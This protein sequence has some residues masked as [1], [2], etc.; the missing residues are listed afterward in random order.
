MSLSEIMFSALPPDNGAPLHDECV[1]AICA[2][3]LHLEPYQRD[4]TNVKRSGEWLN[5]ESRNLVPGGLVKLTLG[6]LIPLCLQS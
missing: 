2:V 5:M 6:G 3:Q 4:V 1:I